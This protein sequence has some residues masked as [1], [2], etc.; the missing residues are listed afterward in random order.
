MTPLLAADLEAAVAGG[1]SPQAA[2][3]RLAD[4][5]KPLMKVMGKPARSIRRADRA[6]WSYNFV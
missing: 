4:T 5:M 3:Q 1:L 2:L 6:S